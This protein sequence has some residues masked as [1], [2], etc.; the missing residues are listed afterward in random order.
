MANKIPT[1]TKL[2]RCKP[3]EQHF[4]WGG[5]RGDAK[6]FSA[7]P[8]LTNA[9][10]TAPNVSFRAANVWEYAEVDHVRQHF[11]C[12]D[13]WVNSFHGEKKEFC[14]GKQNCVTFANKPSTFSYN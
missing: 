9:L 8:I 12:H 3:F 14:T 7:F 11:Q 1:L 4:F 13:H 5:A 10:V 2:H 6:C